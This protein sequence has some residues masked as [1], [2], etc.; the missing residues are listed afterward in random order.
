MI[1]YLL[2]LIL[3]FQPE[4]DPLQV[5]NID[6][7]IHANPGSPLSQPYFKNG[8]EDKAI[9]IIKMLAIKHQLISKD[10][11]YTIDNKGYVDSI[12]YLRKI[13]EDVKD[14][15]KFGEYVLPSLEACTNNISFNRKLFNCLN[16][17]KPFRLY[18]EDIID[19]I[20]SEVE[21]THQIWDNVKTAQDGWCM[22]VRR[23][24]LKNLEKIMGKKALIYGWF[25]DP[26]PY[27]RFEVFPN[28]SSY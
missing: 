9:K 14:L 16:A 28:L 26:V 22:E 6:A 24:S 23:N 10:N 3:P 11:L 13:N 18:Q 5:M 21:F 4:F 7:L 15:P 2:I 25:P 20:I 27:N 8:E 12:E 17:M 19:N 1:T